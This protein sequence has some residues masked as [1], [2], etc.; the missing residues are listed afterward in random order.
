MQ[1]RRRTEENEELTEAQA[2]AMERRRA[3]RRRFNSLGT[4]RKRSG[5]GGVVGEGVGRRRASA[6]AWSRSTAVQ[7]LCSLGP[8]AERRRQ[9]NGGRRR[10][11]GVKRRSFTPAA[12]YIHRQ[13][14]VVG[15]VVLH[16]PDR[17]CGKL[18]RG[19]MEW[20]GGSYNRATRQRWHAVNAL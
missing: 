2:A 6:P 10:W 12:L 4:V 13:V 7:V 14:R 1:K 5:G 11:C 9:R 17:F 3:P 15:V 20:G 18:P 19:G 16:Y 8:A